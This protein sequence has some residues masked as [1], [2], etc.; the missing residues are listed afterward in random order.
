MIFTFE[1]RSLFLNLKKIFF[2][3]VLACFALI[4][5]KYIEVCS[6]NVA[7]S[8]IIQVMYFS[9]LLYTFS[10]LECKIQIN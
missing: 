9:K 4:R 5:I 2:P 6:C 10:K 3:N 8:Q 7:K 1:M